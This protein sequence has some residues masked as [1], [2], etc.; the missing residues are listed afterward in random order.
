MNVQSNEVT[1]RRMDLYRRTMRAAGYDEA[2]VAENV[3]DTWV[4]RNIFVAESDGEAERIARPAFEAQAE[5]RQAMRKRVF[6]EEGLL[7]KPEV[8][9]AARNDPRHALLCGS[10]ATVAEQIAEIDRI[11]V[12]GL[13]LSVV[14]S[15]T[16]AVPRRLPLAVSAVSSFVPV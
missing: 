14:G 12:G 7:L 15:R 2:V 3:A 1:A 8:A 5:F 9:P 10:P 16:G 4:W 13:I 6:E 11:G